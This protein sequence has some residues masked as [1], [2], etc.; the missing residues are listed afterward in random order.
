[1]SIDDGADIPIDCLV[2]RAVRLLRHE[3]TTQIVCTLGRNGPTSFSELRR[4]L[5]GISPKVLTE[6][7]RRMESNALI[8][9]RQEPTGLRRVTYWLTEKGQKIHSA[10]L[11]FDELASD[12][13]D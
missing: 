12:R 6:R 2:D 3:W 7:L 9:R 5:N 10:L 8:S 1:M 11:A 13:R 4:R